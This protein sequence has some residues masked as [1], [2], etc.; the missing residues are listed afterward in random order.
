MPGDA[1]RDA[2]GVAAGVAAWDA[3]GVAARDAAGVAAW[4]AATYSRVTF[5]CDG[6]KL[7]QEHR[8]H[9]KKRMEVW[10]KGYG[11]Y[12]DVNGVLYVYKKI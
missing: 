4:D 8:V 6:L 11:L 5:I 12:C 2:A 3:A 10:Q 9:V 1:A 7:E